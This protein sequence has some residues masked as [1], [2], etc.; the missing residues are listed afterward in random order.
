MGNFKFAVV[1]VSVG[2][3]LSLFRPVSVENGTGVLVVDHESTTCG[4]SSDGHYECTV[5]L[6]NVGG[7][8]AAL[9]HINPGCGC[10]SVLCSSRHLEPGGSSELKFSVRAATA[11]ADV[12]QFDL[13]AGVIRITPSCRVQGQFHHQ[14]HQSGSLTVAPVGQIALPFRIKPSD[15][16][17]PTIVASNGPTE[18]VI[19][20][21]LTEP[22]SDVT[23]L[24]LV[25]GVVATVSR[26]DDDPLGKMTLKLS[27]VPDQMP[28]SF[29][30]QAG[31]VAEIRLQGSI[32]SGLPV[33]LLVPLKVRVV[34]L[35]SISPSRLVV[36]PMRVGES[37]SR[38]L[39][40]TADGVSITSVASIQIAPEQDMLTIERIDSLGR[41]ARA[42]VTIN[43]DCVKSQTFTAS[44]R[45]T[46]GLA[47]ETIVRLPVTVVVKNP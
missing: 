25:S 38:E 11:S 39:Q 22:F 29:H 2:I 10:T 41:S 5:L 27:A 13:G 31:S 43:A 30:G 44:F 47:Q 3:V 19:E 9:E 34:P 1:A 15:F 24:S 16:E 36:G 14:S 23:A 12:I 18:R 8:T 37:L 46:D 33:S 6:K 4:L 21:E 40:F 42:R 45:V 17:L 35:I 32:G 7:G 20:I 26:P 28:E